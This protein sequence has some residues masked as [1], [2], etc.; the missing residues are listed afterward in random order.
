MKIKLTPLNI[1]SAIC[2]VVAGLLLFSQKDQQVGHPQF[3]LLLA[4]VNGLA[5][6][7]FFISDLIFRRF[8]PSLKKLWIVE[9]ALVVFIVV[10]VLIITSSLK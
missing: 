10:L 1:V 4:G 8:I 6:I 7:I 9:G 3:T 5:A 2:L